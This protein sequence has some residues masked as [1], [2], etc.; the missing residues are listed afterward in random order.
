MDNCDWTWLIYWGSIAN[1][2]NF[3]TK[4]WL[5]FGGLFCCTKSFLV[6]GW[7]I[8]NQYKEQLFNIISIALKLFCVF[9]LYKFNHI[10]IS[11]NTYKLQD[12][13]IYI[14]PHLYFLF[15]S[16]PHYLLKCIIPS[17]VNVPS[18]SPIISYQQSVSCQS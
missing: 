1:S 3:G 17:Q 14:K 16:S 9:S 7:F 15:F 2:K 5:L 18:R 6:D 12:Y 4:A 13:L 10:V 11:R 8:W